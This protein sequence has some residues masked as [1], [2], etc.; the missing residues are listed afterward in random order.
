MLVSLFTLSSYAQNVV[1]CRHL[2]TP[3][4]TPRLNFTSYEAATVNGK[5]I[6]IKTL[7]S[8]D[9]VYGTM[10]TIHETVQLG[11]IRSLSK[12]LIINYGEET[13]VLHSQGSDLFQFEI[14]SV[15]RSTY[16]PF[17]IVR[18][19]TSVDCTT[20]IQALDQLKIIDTIVD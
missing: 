11:S 6:L 5:G 14:E 20:D 8:K 1:Y 12:D 2:S 7:F 10:D 16:P 9:S 19:I 4:G 15:I 17:D 18:M 3:N 13:L